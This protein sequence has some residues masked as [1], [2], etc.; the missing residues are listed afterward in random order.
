MENHLSNPLGYEPL[1]KLLRSF[2]VP[3]VIAMLVSSLYNIV[4]QIFIG[5]GVG[6]L[7]N[8]ATNVAYPLTTI[9]LA[10][11]LLIGIG[12]ASRFSLSLGAG[13]PEQAA[14]VVGNAIAMMA[15]LGILYALLVELFLHPLLLA[16]GATP[17]VMPYAIEYTRITALGMP[18][19]IVTNAMSNLARADGSPKYSMTCMLVGA[20]INTILDPIF[21]F[22]FHQGVAGAALA[23]VI[24]QFFSFLLA[25]RYAFHFQH[26][27]LRREHLRLSLSESL[28]TA[29]LGMSSSL[30]Q[31]A[32]T[33]VQ[34]V[35]NNSLTHYGASSIYGTDIPLAACGIV[36]KTNAILLAVV[37]GIS[38]GS[39]PI[40]GFN[41]GAKQYDRVRG[42]YRLAIGCNLVVSLVGFLLFQFCPR[43]IISIFGSGNALYFEFAVRFMRIFLFMVLVNG[44]QMLSS[45]FFSAIGKPVKGLV[46]SMTRQVL[47]LIPLLLLLPILMGGIDGILFAGP[48]ADTMAFLTTV[49]LVSREMKRIRGLEAQNAG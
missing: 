40:I 48:V 9:C 39:Q 8:A 26:I 47:F 12:S 13:E 35:I 3:S 19:L 37:I 16:F 14:R 45:S 42:I 27:N 28:Q 38:Q 10:I 23:T 46:L 25:A 32:I 33:F 21:I 49:C 2:A 29:S 34:I 17:D 11:A 4:D 24:G 1:P 18:L 43:Q 7:G 5:Q 31:V 44:V 22:V 30:N 41:Y 6:Y 15:V 20:V 36:M